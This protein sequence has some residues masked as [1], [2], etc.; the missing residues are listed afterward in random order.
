MLTSNLA[1]KKKETMYFVL[2]CIAAKTLVK[3]QLPPNSAFATNGN[4]IS[5]VDRN[6]MNVFEQD[7]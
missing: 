5:E 3:Q 7:N 2:L 6:R 1:S 4:Y